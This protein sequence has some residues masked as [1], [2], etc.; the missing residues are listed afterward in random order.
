VNRRTSHRAAASPSPPCARTGAARTTGLLLIL[1]VLVGGALRAAYLAELVHKPD[2]DSPLSDAQYNDYWARGLVTGQWTPP[3]GEPDPQ[4]QTT[5]FFRPPGYAYFL[6]GVY[7]LTGT[8]YL[9]PRLVQMAIGL[10]NIVLVFFVG[11]AVFARPVGLIAA[12]LVATYW[13]FIYF[14]GEFHP[15]SLLIALLLW[16]ILV[17]HG[18]ALRPTIWRAAVAGLLL[19]LFAVVRSNVLLFVPFLVLWMAWVLWRRRA[20][21][22]AVPTLLSAAALLGGVVTPVVPVTVRNY[23]VGHGLVLVSTNGGINLYI[24]NNPQTSLV[25]PR[26][27]DIERLTARAG[28]N[29]F[30]WTE[31]I[32]G[33]SA[34][35]GR[36]MTSSE[37]SQYFTKRAW[38]FIRVQPATALRYAAGR[39]ALLWGPQEVS[40]N[41][42]DAYEQSRTWP[43][44]L[45]PGF[46]VALAGLM[47]GLVL[48]L[49]D[50]RGVRNH[51]Q[52]PDEGE[53]A[54][55]ASTVLLLLFMAVYSASF[56]PFLVAGRFRMPY[57]PLLLLFGAY[58]L[59]RIG[60]FAAARQGKLAWA[61]AAGCLAAWGLAH[62]QLVPYK[63][64]LGAWFLDRATAY[65]Q[66]GAVEA[67]IGEYRAAINS[68]PTYSVPYAALATALVKRG[69]A[70]GAIATYQQ[71]V[72]MTPQSAE[73]RRALASL[74]Q[75]HKRLA[76]ALVQY[77]AIVEISPTHAESWYH[78][79]QCLE[80]TG[81]PA[82][83]LKAYVR[84]A[85]LDPKLAQAHVNAGVLWQNQGDLGR[86]ANEYQ[87]AIDS[88]PN[89]FEA[90]F[91]LAGVLV[92]RGELDAA[93]REISTALN[94]DPRHPKAL[95]ALKY[96]QEKR[97][98]AATRPT[99]EP[100]TPN[101][102]P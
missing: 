9:A 73:M 52:A 96:L 72:Q 43:L 80:A 40:N 56:A 32:T 79:G 81:A 84:A 92:A 82:D 75:D 64:D 41:K 23:V 83:A 74:L 90:H 27:P 2:Y 20:G 5:P 93:Y 78:L 54:R 69:D 29:L 51:G 42:V 91:D 44:R 49:I 12:A 8:G 59:W 97:E 86:A 101:P 7:R 58:G 28:W 14:E 99:T 6:A 50:R 21:R 13:G 25:T 19:G 39:M 66:K 11:R 63:P 65:A 85:E 55:Q 102:E 48:W 94:I 71:A 100:Q 53:R 1:I 62:V 36:A 24:G 38:G 10:L 60:Q 45:L 3:N 17:L 26:I 46:P 68:A 4:I 76:E 95:A 34:L 31:I 61:G 33:I 16:L 67:S 57:I 77:R 88:E 22:W 37:V 87:R 47:V 70:E 15:K 89:L 98:K 30:R 35:E 18:W